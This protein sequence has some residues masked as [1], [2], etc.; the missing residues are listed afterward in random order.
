VATQDGKVPV[1]TD[2]GEE[3]VVRPAPVR[4]SLR[5]LPSLNLRLTIEEI[6]TF[7]R[8]GR[9]RDCG[10]DRHPGSGTPP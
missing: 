9:E 7:V 4:R 5:D 1:R 3:F 6:V 2:T 10:L 8:E